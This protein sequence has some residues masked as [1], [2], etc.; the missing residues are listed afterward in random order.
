MGPE[1]EGAVLHAGPDIPAELFCYTQN[2]SYSHRVD[3]RGNME[4]MAGS[5]QTCTMQ[6]SLS[7]CLL[8]LH[9]WAWGG[10]DV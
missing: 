9:S 3:N 4:R 1:G 2:V 7:C 8:V 10:T 5:V 6:V